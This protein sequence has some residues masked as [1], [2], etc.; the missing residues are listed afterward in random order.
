M[1]W[2]IERRARNRNDR[3]TAGRTFP[4][5]ISGT[6]NIK[7]KTKN[8]KKNNQK[9]KDDYEEKSSTSNGNVISDMVLAKKIGA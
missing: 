1:H 3:R 5:L 6:V 9:E 4:F 8:K 7:Q 2:G